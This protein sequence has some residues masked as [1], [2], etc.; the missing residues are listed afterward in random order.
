MRDD[1]AETLYTVVANFTPDAMILSY[2]MEVRR[3]NES[4][5]LQNSSSSTCL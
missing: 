3:I 4:T 5:K 2:V 1:V